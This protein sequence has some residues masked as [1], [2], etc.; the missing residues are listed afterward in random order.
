MTDNVSRLPDPGVVLDLDT[1]ERPEEEVKSP[2]VVNVSGKKITLKDPAEVD[3]RD[4]ASVEIPGDL[5]R[6]A[7][8]NEDRRHL[9]EA[10]LPSWKF[11][12]LM[13]GYYIHYDLEDKIRKAKQQ[14]QFGA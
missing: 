11:N 3:W 4:L 9:Q 7:M 5:L 13:E 14:S 2:F 8:S 10:A 6:V 12:K 1:A